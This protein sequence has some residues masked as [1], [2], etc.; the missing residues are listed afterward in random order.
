[1]KAIPFVQ[2]DIFALSQSVVRHQLNPLC[3]ASQALQEGSRFPNVLR[4]VVDAGNQRHPE[5]KF[6]VAFNNDSCVRQYE[7]VW[8][9]GELTVLQ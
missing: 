8:L 4:S 5:Q 2:R 3:S 9:T 1:M 7:I 6:H